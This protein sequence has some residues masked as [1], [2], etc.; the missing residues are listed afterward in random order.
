MRQ[1]ISNNKWKINNL[2]G[3]GVVFVC[4][5]GVFIDWNIAAQDIGRALSELHIPGIPRNKDSLADILLERGYALAHYKTAENKKTLR[6]RYW[7]I[8]AEITSKEGVKGCSNFYALRL[9]EAQLIFGDTKP[10]LTK[11]VVIKQEAN[12][13]STE[14]SKTPPADT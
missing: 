12:L 2:S 8:E 11:K 6:Y 5:E 3:E 7:P 10:T 1:F 13:E 14:A 4:E 9:E